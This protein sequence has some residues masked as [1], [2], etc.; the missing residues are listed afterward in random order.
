MFALVFLLVVITSTLITFIL[1]ESFASSTRIK[2]ERKTDAATEGKQT[3]LSS[4]DPHVAH[5]QLEMLRSELILKPVIEEMN[6][7]AKWGKK[8]FG[9]KDQLKTSETLALLRQRLDVRSVWDTRQLLPAISNL[10]LDS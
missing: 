9:G 6:L 3:S 1:P 7:N 8:Y 4:Y 10:L 2:V 5:T